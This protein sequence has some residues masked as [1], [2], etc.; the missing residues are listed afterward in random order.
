MCLAFPTLSVARAS[1]NLAI[2]EYTPGG[3]GLNFDDTLFE[4]YHNFRIIAYFGVMIY[5]LVFHFMV[6]MLFERYGSVP[7]ILKNVMNLIRGSNKE[8]WEINGTDPSRESLK[9]ININNFET[10]QDKNSTT[11][12]LSA[13]NNNR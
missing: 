6:G 9:E 5:A 13:E 10:Q 4:P 2:Y 8:A 3:T 11:N 7:E 12:K 1:K